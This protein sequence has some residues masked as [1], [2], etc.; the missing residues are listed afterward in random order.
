MLSNLLIRKTSI[1][2]KKILQTPI[3]FHKLHHNDLFSKRGCF[4]GL[5]LNRKFSNIP[6][7]LNIEDD[8]KVTNETVEYNTQDILKF[9]LVK[10]GYQKS[11]GLWLLF[12]AG[13]VLGMIS[14]GGYTRMS[15]SGLSM[16]KWKPLFY[17]YPQ[18]QQE[19]D[20][21]YENYKVPFL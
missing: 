8:Q 10:E 21:E 13:A 14:L 15:R 5:I 4:S 19:W 16:V 11:V 9:K 18:S 3:R 7:A 17:R 12:M 2:T 1:L 6:K 20:E